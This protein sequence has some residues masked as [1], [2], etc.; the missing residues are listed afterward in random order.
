MISLSARPVDIHVDGLFVPVLRYD[1]HRLDLIAV[2]R[3]DIFDRVEDGLLGSRDARSEIRLPD[4]AVMRDVLGEQAG[5]PRATQLIV[6]PSDD[7]DDRE[8]NHS[9]QDFD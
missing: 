7:R 4:V 1:A 8:N 9:S 2:G 3:F 6:V 5:L